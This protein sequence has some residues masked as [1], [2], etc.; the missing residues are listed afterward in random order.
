MEKVLRR[1]KNHL[2]SEKIRSI[3][4]D[5]GWTI[6]ALALMNVVS[7]FMVY[8]V[9]AKQFG[10]EVY[11]NI[12]Y[13][14]SLINIFAVSV[15]M[16]ANYARMAESASRETVNG[17][18]NRILFAGGILSGIICFFILS[19]GEF[20]L[21]KCDAV[22]AGV[23]CAFTLWR[24]YG[25]VEYRMKLDYKGYFLY[26]L[27]VSA[28]YLFGILLFWLTGFWAVALLPGEGLGLFL[29]WKKGKLFRESPFLQGKNARENTKTVLLLVVTNFISNTIF[30]GDRILLQNFL[31]GTA[32][33]IYYL[34]SLM[35]KTMSLISTPL[36]S[37]I[38]GYLA[39]YRGK[40]TGKMA[41][42]LFAGAMV[43][44]FLG[45]AVA[46]SASYLLIRILYPQSFDMVKSYFVIGNLAQVIYFVTNI[47]TTVLLR[48][49]KAD[50]QLKINVCY[51]IFFLFLCVPAA[52]LYGI[53]GFCYGLL[54][55][56]VIR[57]L[58]AIYYCS[59]STVRDV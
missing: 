54:L 15:G 27:T 17:D 58:A 21:S 13:S 49:A 25:D 57:Y 44:V 12:V 47:I 31:G 38:I 52:D 16:S 3:C 19:Y 8:P 51:A 29:V 48:I 32:V 40:F 10:S 4:R 2:W 53:K 50:C 9:W 14:M 1:M 45:T 24:Y 35:G 36:N 56:N 39:R 6:A 59:K 30:N 43:L 33:T 42:G 26:Y 5:S 18:Y 41:A 28:G 23:L 55:V 7:Q 22:L 37:V 46:V 11:G 20:H 34:A